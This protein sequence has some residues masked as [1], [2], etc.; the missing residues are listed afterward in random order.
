MNIERSLWAVGVN[1]RVDLANAEA[2]I[3]ERL[4]YQLMI[5]GVT[6][7]APHRVY[8]ETDVKVGHD[9]TINDVSLRGKSTI[10]NGCTIGQGSVSSIVSLK[11]GFR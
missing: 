7:T 6:L 4:A 5:E 8:L 9:T 10:G 1:N 3:Q 11:M 2:Q